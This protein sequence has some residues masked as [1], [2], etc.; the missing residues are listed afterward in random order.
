ML[1]SFD[2]DLGFD[3]FNYVTVLLSC[4]GFIFFIN[5]FSLHIVVNF[6]FDFYYPRINKNI[7]CK[8]YSYWLN[9]FADTIYSYTY[10]PRAKRNSLYIYRKVSG[11]LTATLFHIS[12]ILFQKDA[13][14][15]LTCWCSSVAWLVLVSHVILLVNVDQ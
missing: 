1:S 9:G 6:D 14:Q 13:L 3:R 10:Q 12:W 11:S 15:I 8:A 5:I 7:K 4:C 2:Y